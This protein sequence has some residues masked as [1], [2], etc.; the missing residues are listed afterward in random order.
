MCGG[1]HQYLNLVIKIINN[2]ENNISI[3]QASHHDA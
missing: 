2:S 3:L 1:N